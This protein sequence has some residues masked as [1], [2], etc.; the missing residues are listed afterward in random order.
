MNCKDKN[1][2]TCEDNIYKN[3]NDVQCKKDKIIRSNYICDYCD[4]DN[5]SCR[6]KMCDIKYMN[7][8]IF[9][10]GK[11]VMEVK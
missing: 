11:I 10:K 1:C 3:K 9:F 2:L 7:V 8:D 4:R 5:I 6:E